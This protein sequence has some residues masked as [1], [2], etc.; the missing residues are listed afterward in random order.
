[1]LIMRHTDEDYFQ[2]LQDALLAALLQ[3]SRDPD[4]K[5]AM[6]RSA[7]LVSACINL[8]GIFAA[9]STA[10]DTPEKLKL[11]A[12]ECAWRIARSILKT[13]ELA[14]AG[15]LPTITAVRADRRH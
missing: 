15:E 8:I 12:Q 9:S 11:F 4:S 7:E 1:M 5:V 13:Q 6:V 14:A 10:V 2:R 3:V